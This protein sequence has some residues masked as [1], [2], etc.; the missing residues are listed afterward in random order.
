MFIRGIGV[1]F[2]KTAISL[3]LRKRV[4]IMLQQATII[5]KTTE[6]RQQAWIVLN[7]RYKLVFRCEVIFGILPYVI[8]M[9]QGIET[10]K[11]L[12]HYCFFVHGTICTVTE[13][14]VRTQL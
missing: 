9:C 2:G 10:C 7:M 11:I 4:T 12:D 1:V 8:L 6:L 5:L 3:H 13:L 14:I